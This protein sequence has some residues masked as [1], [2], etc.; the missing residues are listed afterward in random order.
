MRT[1]QFEEWDHAYGRYRLEE[2]PAQCIGRSCAMA[3]FDPGTG[4]YYCGHIKPHGNL[5]AK[6]IDLE[7]YHG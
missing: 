5:M 4:R 3:L 7:P 2:R 1:E 6:P